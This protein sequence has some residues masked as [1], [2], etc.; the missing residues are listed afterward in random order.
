[1]AVHL[2]IFRKYHRVLSILVCLPLAVMALTGTISPILEAL[3]LE[4]A[5]ALIRRIH[6]GRIVLGSTYPV[7]TGVTG[8]ALLGLLATGLSLFKRYK[9]PHLKRARYSVAEGTQ[10][11][12]PGS[13]IENLQL[14]LYLLLPSNE[15]QHLVNLIEGR[16]G[17]YEGN[18]FVRA[19]LQHLQN[20]GLV[21]LKPD[22]S[23]NEIHD[24]LLFNLADYVKL[25][26][27]GH[28]WIQQV[29]AIEDQYSV[30]VSRSAIS[31]LD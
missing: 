29:P 12:N 4:Q 8:L 9:R 26:A 10:E 2:T 16:T 1:M 31:L 28:D 18:Q 22:R 15:R 24:R 13:Q 27:I 19:E 23:L 30:A 21:T 11:R 5:T 7:Y 6:S 17:Q 14:I 20:L 25:T 3:Q